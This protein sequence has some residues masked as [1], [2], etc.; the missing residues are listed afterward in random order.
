MLL[1]VDVNSEAEG[2]QN[3]M[4]ARAARRA[5]IGDAELFQAIAEAQAGRVDDLGGGV[6]KK[7]LSLNRYRSIV[8]TR[9]GVTWVF[10]YL[11]AKQDRANID[12][13]ELLGFR[14]L[15]KTYDDMTA[16]EL[17][18]L[19]VEQELTEICHEDQ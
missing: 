17:S 12:T 3:Q 19:I 5:R 9:S 15:A 14:K 4:F 11:F 18:A 13:D 16:Q 1:F 7:R 8:L 6:F 10:V 2:F